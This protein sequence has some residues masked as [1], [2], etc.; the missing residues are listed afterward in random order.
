MKVK[1]GETIW[2]EVVWKAATRS[3]A[4]NMTS[5]SGQVSTY[6]YTLLP[7]QTET[8][9][10][11]YF[12]LEYDFLCY[13]LFCFVLYCVCVRVF[14]GRYPYTYAQVCLSGG[15]SGTFMLHCYDR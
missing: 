10:A 8:E 1:P 6:E 7:A 9:S 11:G 5:S 2:A 3:Y 4:M 15:T 12:V 14:Y 13:V